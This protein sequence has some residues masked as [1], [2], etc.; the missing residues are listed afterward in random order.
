MLPFSFGEEMTYDEVLATTKWNDVVS[1]IYCIENKLNG[2]K[3]IGL[4]SSIYGRWRDH[5]L[6][7]GSC[8]AIHGA[9]NKYGID[10]FDFSI[11][12]VCEADKLYEKEIE[13]IAKHNSIFPN[14]YNLT[15]GGDGARDVT[16]HTKEIMRNIMIEKWEDPEHREMFLEAFNTPEA[17]ARRA[18]ATRRRYEDE[19]VREAHSEMLRERWADEEYKEKLKAVNYAA[20]NNE[21]SEE[22]RKR[23]GERSKENWESMSQ[24]NKDKIVSALNDW[25]NDPEKLE[26]ARLK[27]LET[28]ATP[29]FK[30]RKSKALIKAFECPEKR[31]VRSGLST[32]MWEDEEHR[33]KV[34][35][36]IKEAYSKPEMKIKRCFYKRINGHVPS[37]EEGWQLV[38]K[39]GYGQEWYDFAL[40]YYTEYSKRWTACESSSKPIEQ[41]T[42]HHEQS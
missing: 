31:K 6:A 5:A 41:S 14:G 18:E 13:Y 38:Q 10:C 27:R 24:E 20:W 9:I 36:A 19:E 33:S 12:E 30:E 28:F 16:E 42:S 40:S 37:F 23:A 29:E 34:S 26:Q 4:S 21:N 2:K 8:T 25:K 35:A 22:R 11:L 7:N 1:G 15:S 3:Y 32:K 17:K 39:K